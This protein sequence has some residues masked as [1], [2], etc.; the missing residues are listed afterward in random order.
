MTWQPAHWSQASIGDIQIAEI[1]VVFL[2]IGAGL[3]TGPHANR[4][5]NSYDGSSERTGMVRVMMRND[6]LGH[7]FAGP[8]DI[9]RLSPQAQR[10]L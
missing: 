6:G 3:N 5:T 2:D 4:L 8:L 10:R 9:H 1:D 7:G